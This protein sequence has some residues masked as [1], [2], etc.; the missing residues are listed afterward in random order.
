MRVIIA[1]GREVTDPKVLLDAIKASGF[2]ITEVVSGGARGVDTMGEFWASS[3][4]VPVKR[5]PAD[6]KTY[7]PSA[8]PIRNQQMAEY[9]EALIAIP[10]GG[11]GTA[12]MIRIAKKQ[13]LRVY[14]H[15]V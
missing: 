11:P 8:G 1:G 14:V 3:F 5:F 10:T 7:G 13:G 2:L 6:W 15:Q 4:G 9:A 12:S